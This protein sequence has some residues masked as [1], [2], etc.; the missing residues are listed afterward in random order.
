MFP[1]SPPL[2]PVL[3]FQGEALSAP[4]A[5]ALLA[6]ARTWRRREPKVIQ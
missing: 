3:R 1:F 2:L 6:Q 5:G 4:G